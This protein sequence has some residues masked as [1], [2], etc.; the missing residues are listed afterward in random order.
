MYLH[1]GIALFVSF[2]L[3]IMS[4]CAACM[5]SVVQVVGVNN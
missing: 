3:E 2:Y 1:V 4:T 5:A